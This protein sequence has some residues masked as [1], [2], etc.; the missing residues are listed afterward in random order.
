M[1]ANLVV[2]QQ[3]LEQL[4]IEFLERDGVKRIGQ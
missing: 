4:G 1:R 3:T 2:L